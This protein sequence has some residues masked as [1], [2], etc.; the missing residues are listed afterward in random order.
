MSTKLDQK[1]P[2]VSIPLKFDQTL[3]C[4][5]FIKSLEPKPAKKSRSWFALA[6]KINAVAVVILS[7]AAIALSNNGDFETPAQRFHREIGEYMHDCRELGGLASIKENGFACLVM[8][9]S[10]RPETYHNVNDATIKKPKAKSALNPKYF[11]GIENLDKDLDYLPKTCASYSLD[12][13][14]TTEENWAKTVLNVSNCEDS[15]KAYR[16]LSKKLH[17]DKKEPQ[18]TPLFHC[19]AEANSVLKMNCNGLFKIKER[20]TT[21]RTREIGEQRDK[22][23]SHTP[24]G[25]LHVFEH[26]FGINIDGEAISIWTASGQYNAITKDGK[27]YYEKEMGLEPLPEETA[28]SGLFS[29]FS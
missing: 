17:P 21:N 1:Y 7:V 23:L 4:A 29:F 19:V 16:Q 5:D 12:Q 13:S 20:Y 11:A 10:W 22:C 27:S 26:E 24:S 2:D 14:L 8:G 6:L 15:S 25:E 18:L 28:K 3:I 9:L